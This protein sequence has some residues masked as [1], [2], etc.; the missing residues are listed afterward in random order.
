MQ[1]I[2]PEEIVD[3]Y[4]MN[5]DNVVPGVGYY[6]SYHDGADAFTACALGAHGCIHH[7]PTSGMDLYEL[8]PSTG[9][10]H[11][12]TIGFDNF[13]PSTES[14]FAYV[15]RETVPDSLKDEDEVIECVRGLKDGATVRQLLHDRHV[16][17][18]PEHEDYEDGE[19]DEDDNLDD[20]PF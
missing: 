14:L 6:F 15:G 11:G 10:R 18:L 7:G 2:V 5:Q 9:Y 1:Y 20:V 13:D 8:A 16:D 17:V 12:V 4:V 3:Y 19:E